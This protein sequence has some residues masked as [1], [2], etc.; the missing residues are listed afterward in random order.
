M[1]NRRTYSVYKAA[2]LLIQNTYKSSGSHL[3]R[4]S[5]QSS[6]TRR[7]TSALAVNVMLP[8][9]A[10]MPSPA[11]TR[12]VSAT[13]CR[14]PAMMPASKKSNIRAENSTSRRFSLRP[15]R[16]S[17]RL[18][19]PPSMLLRAPW[20]LSPLLSLPLPPFSGKWLF[21]WRFNIN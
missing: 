4:T 7:I 6:S 16:F 19:P 2:A 20:P 5:L 9:S 3:T 15:A 12:C 13:A 10:A 1:E 18:F 17:T 21:T 8:P 11:A 14:T